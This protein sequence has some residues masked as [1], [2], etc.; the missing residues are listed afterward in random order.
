MQF[1]T[2]VFLTL[3]LGAKYGPF[4]VA[5]ILV[6]T[7]NVAIIIA[8]YMLVNLSCVLYYLRERRSEFNVVLHGLIPLAGIAV[9]VPAFFT[10]VGIGKSV[11]S[12]VFPLPSP[13]NLVGVVDGILMGV[14]VL[15]LIA[16]ALL[17]PARLRDTGRVF[18]EEPGAAAVPAS[19][20]VEERTPEP[21][22]SR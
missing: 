4:P 12:F 9:F 5:F 11:F 20:V 19:T 16:L 14:G 22:S 7:I 1:A 13:Y 8:I 3:W 17:A 6:A 2:G 21:G 18:V 15:Y 10:A